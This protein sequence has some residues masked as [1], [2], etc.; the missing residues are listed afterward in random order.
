VGDLALLVLVMEMEMDS[1]LSMVGVLGS[2]SRSCEER[3]RKRDEYC[4]GQPDPRRQGKS[5]QKPLCIDSNEIMDS[6]EM[7]T[8]QFMEYR[9]VLLYLRQLSMVLVEELRESEDH[10]S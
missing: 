10:V 6:L 4:E 3:A 5:M 7:Q 9:I 2:R 1:L 8:Y